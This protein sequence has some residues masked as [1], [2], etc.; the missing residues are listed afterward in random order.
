MDELEGVVDDVDGQ[1]ELEVEERRIAEELGLDLLRA[2]DL[3]GQ[4]SAAWGCMGGRR[5]ERG[6]RA[7]C[8]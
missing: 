1:G 8:E 2:L 3:H 6:R 4:T 5:H 7:M